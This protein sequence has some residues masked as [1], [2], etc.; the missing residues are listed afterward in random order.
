[1]KII[2]NLIVGAVLSVA[3]TTNCQAT[4]LRVLSS[5]AENH[6]Y[7]REIGKVYMDLVSK[8]SN[9][10][11]T[12]SLF[13]P[14]AIP[15]FEQLEPT[16]Q[17]LFDVLVTHPVYHYSNTG[18]GTAI[19]ATKADSALRRSSGLFEF[20]DD[21]YQTLGLK[22]LSAPLMGSK[23]FKYVL[24]DPITASPAFEGRK[25]RGTPSYHP[26]IIALGGTPDNTPPAE[27][28]TALEKGIFDGA[29]FGRVGV[30]DLKLNEVAPYLATPAFG[31]VG[32]MVF[33]NLD[34]W[35]SLSAE[36]QQVLLAQGEKLEEVSVASFDK[37]A[38]DEDEWLLSNGM[39]LTEFLPEDKERLDMLM[40]NGVWE[41]AA[42]RSPEEVAK[43]RE[44]AEKAGL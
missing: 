11:I 25:I 2:R 36:E 6:A 14:D 20:I 3:V 12:F 8:A 40:N 26:M 19:D 37:L 29:A 7:T 18:V 5:W 24:R 4:E 43:M 23:G 44:L 31:T 13:G 38:A 9:G 16:S 28:Y 22:L 35:N 17:G 1:M 41:V 42:K 33:M 27:I 21:Y 39:E 34:R 15:S 32:L 30:K 10:D